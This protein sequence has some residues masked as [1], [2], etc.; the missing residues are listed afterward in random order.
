MNYQ[1]FMHI[2]LLISEYVI[3]YEMVILIRLYL[4]MNSNHYSGYDGR[5]FVVISHVYMSSN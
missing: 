1:W 2:T 5:L 4:A 3:E